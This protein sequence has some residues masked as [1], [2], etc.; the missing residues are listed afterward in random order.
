M[1][2]FGDSFG[3]IRKNQ[4]IC[5]GSTIHYKYIV[6]NLLLDAQGKVDF[7]LMMNVF[8]G[9]TKVFEDSTSR[10]D[11]LA[12]RGGTMPGEAR[13]RTQHV[14][15][16]S[17]RVNVV[18]QIAKA[19]AL[20]DFPFA[21]AIPSKTIIEDMSW[22]L[23]KDGVHRAPLSH[24]MLGQALFGQI[25]VYMPNTSKGISLTMDA[26]VYEA[27]TDKLMC[28]LHVPIT[29]TET[30]IHQVT[31]SVN[32]ALNRAGQFNVVI[33]ITDLLANNSVTSVRIPLTV[34]PKE[35]IEPQFDL[36]QDLE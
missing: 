33:K 6:N 1:C 31:F 9:S 20:M 35:I 24:L 13:C 8:Q 22:T 4:V 29:A 27:G 2:V 23:D 11:T 17:V 15:Q 32:F 21:C 18:D 26:S 3:L 5:P 25:L 19:T 12:L 30:E 34:Y 10:R 16:Y 14:G 36:P 7:E 28:L